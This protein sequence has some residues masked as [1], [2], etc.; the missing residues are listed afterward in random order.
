MKV[1]IVLH[2]MKYV[3]LNESTYHLLRAGSSLKANLLHDVV[4]QRVYFTLHW[5]LNSSF[6]KMKMLFS[7]KGRAGNMDLLGEE[8]LFRFWTI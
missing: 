4:I 6:R 7:A 1:L 5:H 3:I 2:T 8:V